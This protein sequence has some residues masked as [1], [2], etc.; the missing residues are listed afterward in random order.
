MRDYSEII[1][2]TQTHSQA[3]KLLEE[4][5]ELEAAGFGQPGQ[6]ERTLTE[7]VR[8]GVAEAMRKGVGETAGWSEYLGG[9]KN[10]VK[11]WETVELGL[12]FEPSETGLERIVEELRAAIGVPVVVRVRVDPTVVGGAVITYKGIYRDLSVKRLLNDLT[13]QLWS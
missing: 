8:Q 9:L 5:E 12:A 3:E 2:V 10:Q 11:E 4:I 6:L 13:Q 7:K 1:S